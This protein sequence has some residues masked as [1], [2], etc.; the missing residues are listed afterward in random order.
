MNSRRTLADVRLRGE[1][2]SL[3]PPRVED[4]QRA[5][6]LLAGRR[7]ILDWLEWAGPSSVDEMRAHARAW[8]TSSDDASNYRLAIYANHEAQAVV[9]AISLRFVDHPERCDLGYWIG[10]EHQG[11]GYAGETLRNSLWLVFEVLEAQ[12]A[13]ACVFVGNDASRRMLEKHGFE[14]TASETTTCAPRERWNFA[15]SAEAWRAAGAKQRPLEFEL[16]FDG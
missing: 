8:R 15:L 7:E 13:S 16:A 2:V 9:G 5:Y 10:V 6:T 3:A 12:S 14:L 11:R 4:A 1:L